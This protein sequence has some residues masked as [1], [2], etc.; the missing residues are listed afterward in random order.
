M[1]IEFKKFFQIYFSKVEFESFKYFKK[2][3]VDDSSYIKSSVLITIPPNLSHWYDGIT[4]QDYLQQVA[5]VIKNEMQQLVQGV[6]FS[7][8]KKS[9]NVNFI[10]II[11]NSNSL[12]NYDSIQNMSRKMVQQ[13]S[14]MNFKNIIANGRILSDYISDSVSYHYDSMNNK[15]T[16]SSTFSK[17][18][19]LFGKINVFVDAFMRYNDEFILTF[20]DIYFDIKEITPYISVSTPGNSQLKVEFKY[21]TNVLNPS[22][23]Y[24][25]DSET[26]TNYYMF[27]SERRDEIIDK[28]LNDDKG[29]ES[30]F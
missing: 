7:A 21:F 20:D 5:G 12:T 23:V 19:T 16:S 2:T 8:I 26:S 28:L 6:V 17:N 13:I 22:V 25:V 11:D 18:G 14:M 1:E 15:V 10:N 9:N 29:T 3:K 27:K 30:N 4:E 24:I